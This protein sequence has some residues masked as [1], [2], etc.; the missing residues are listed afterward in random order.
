MC[1]N[2]QLDDTSIPLARGAA[3]ATLPLPQVASL[4]A[5]GLQLSRQFTQARREG[6]RLALLWIEASVPTD[7]ALGSEACAELLAAASQRMRNR[8]RSTDAVVQVAG[9][10]F[11]VLLQAAGARE[12][13]LVERRLLHALK[14]DYGL[15]GRLVHLEV[16]LGCAVFPEAGRQGT[17]LAAAAQQDLLQRQAG[18]RGVA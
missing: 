15:A 18:L 3:A 8:V 4:A 1:Q 12:A 17:E 6:E 2:P 16:K 14:G 13:A 9:Q 11:A 5:L 7:A 10:G